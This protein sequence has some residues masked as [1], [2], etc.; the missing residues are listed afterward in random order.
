M[1]IDQL[2]KTQ[3]ENQVGARN[4]RHSTPRMR[5][6]LTSWGS[7]RT[8]SEVLENATKTRDHVWHLM[9]KRRTPHSGGLQEKR[10]ASAQRELADRGITRSSGCRHALLYEFF[11][12]ACSCG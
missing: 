11:D 10:A 5:L 7:F 12:Y 9:C 6:S 2:V 8:L 1:D 4:F 3:C